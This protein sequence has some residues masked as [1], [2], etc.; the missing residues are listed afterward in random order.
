MVRPAVGRRLRMAERRGLRI[1]VLAAPSL[2][3]GGNLAGPHVAGVLAGVDAP[4]ML[5]G[6]LRAGRKLR[7][8][9]PAIAEAGKRIRARGIEAIVAQRG[10]FEAADGLVASW[11]WSRPAP[12]CNQE[13]WLGR[14]RDGTTPEPAGRRT[15]ASYRRHFLRASVCAVTL[16]QRAAPSVVRRQRWRRGDAT[17]PR[18][19]RRH[20]R[21]RKHGCGHAG[22]GL[23]WDIVG[24]ACGAATV[25]LA[26]DRRIGRQRREGW[27]HLRQRRADLCQWH[28]RHRRAGGGESAAGRAATHRRTALIVGRG[29]GKRRERARSPRERARSRRERSRS[30]RERPAL[31]APPRS[32]PRPW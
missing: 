2:A 25:H 32:L 21:V 24:Q 11:H 13:S 6:Q 23:K 14:A 22:G 10:V 18:S 12:P 1:G 5:S 4:I 26:V 29:G 9:L 28:C 17:W 16:S 19:R 8:A 30:R 20:T 3:L 31:R 27:T 7:T 15:G